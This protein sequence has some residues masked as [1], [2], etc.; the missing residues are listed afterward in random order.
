MTDDPASLSQAQLRQLMEKLEPPNEEM[1]EIS[2]NIILKR[3]GFDLT[4]LQ[5]DLKNRLK[6]EVDE[7]KA[8]N[9]QSPPE[10]LKLIELL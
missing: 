7:M 3:A 6:R 9:E 1:D 4:A 2:A 10:M 8:R 5:S